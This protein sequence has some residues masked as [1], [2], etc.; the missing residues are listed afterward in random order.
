MYETQLAYQM[1]TIPCT[2]LQDQGRVAGAATIQTTSVD[3]ASQAIGKII[4]QNFNPGFC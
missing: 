4:A 1:Q 2:V 3:H